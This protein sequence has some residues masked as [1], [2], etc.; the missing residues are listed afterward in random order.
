LKLPRS[1]LGYQALDQFENLDFCP[2][3]E[4]YAEL[5]SSYFYYTMFSNKT[6]EIFVRVKIEWNK[7]LMRHII[8]GQKEFWESAPKESIS[9]FRSY[10]DFFPL[11]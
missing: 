3:D 6:Q 8:I 2:M 4:L 1:N 5:L 9:R 11:H 7:S 10:P